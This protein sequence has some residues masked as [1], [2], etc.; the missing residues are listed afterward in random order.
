MKCAGHT[1]TWMYR[2]TDEHLP[3]L[4]HLAGSVNS[5]LAH[6]EYQTICTFYFLFFFSIFEPDLSRLK[7][8]NMNILAQAFSSAQLPWQLAWLSQLCSMMAV[9]TKRSRPSLTPVHS[10]YVL[11]LWFLLLNFTSRYTP[12]WHTW[13]QF[14]F[15]LKGF[16]A[17]QTQYMKFIGECTLDR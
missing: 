7:I 14:L 6:N 10:T 5:R 12:N 16:M 8:Q 17:Y 13:L 3:L 11:H 15:I 1:D 9:A 4:Y 2:Q